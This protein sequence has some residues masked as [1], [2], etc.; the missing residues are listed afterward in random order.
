MHLVTKV[1]KW[2]KKRQLK[3]FSHIG[4]I[5]WFDALNPYYRPGFLTDVVKEPLANQ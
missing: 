5:F 1:V 4:H 3:G 2:R